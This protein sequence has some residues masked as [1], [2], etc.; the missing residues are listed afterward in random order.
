MENLDDIIEMLVGHLPDDTDAYTLLDE[1]LP[2]LEDN[3][4]FPFVAVYET[5]DKRK[6]IKNGTSVKVHRVETFEMPE[7]ILMKVRVSHTTFILPLEE[8]TVTDV[9]SKNFLYVEAY[10]EWFPTI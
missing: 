1:W 5:T 10:K 2:F 3:L 8:L 6:V 7:G 9:N 4:T